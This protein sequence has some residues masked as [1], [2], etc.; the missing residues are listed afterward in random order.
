MLERD[1]ERDLALRR[2][3]ERDAELMRRK[4]CWISWFIVGMFV[5]GVVLVC[6]GR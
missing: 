4:V 2:L 1:W 3:R 6:L 5:L